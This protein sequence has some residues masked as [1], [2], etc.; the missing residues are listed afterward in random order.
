MFN[1]V[2]KS[3]SLIWS[4]DENAKKERELCRGDGMIGGLTSVQHRHFDLSGGKNSPPAA[5]QV[6]NG[7]D[8]TRCTFLDATS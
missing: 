2:P 5:R 6:P 8:L 7:D 1:H 4:F 3:M